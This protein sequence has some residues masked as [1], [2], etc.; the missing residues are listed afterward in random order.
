LKIKLGKIGVPRLFVVF[1]LLLLAKEHQPEKEKGAEAAKP[2]PRPGKKRAERNDERRKY[3]R[4]QR[5]DNSQS[6]QGNLPCGNAEARSSYQHFRAL[7]KHNVSYVIIEA[8]I[9]KRRALSNIFALN[10]TAFF[11]IIMIA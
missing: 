4:D 11:Y 1:L 7:F 9:C 2:R 8:K 10:L 5:K 6:F 3:G